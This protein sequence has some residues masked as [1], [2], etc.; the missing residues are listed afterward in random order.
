MTAHRVSIDPPEPIP[1]QLEKLL[2]ESLKA[3]AALG[4]IEAACRLA[5]QACA[6]LR[7]NS[8]TSWKAF[9][10]FLHRYAGQTPD[11]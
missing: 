4:Q 5:G 7:E 1:P 11:P 3:L 8:P 9:N 2:L 6:A 10:A